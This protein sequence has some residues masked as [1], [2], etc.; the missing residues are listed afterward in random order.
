MSQS[1]LVVPPKI[2]KFITKLTLLKAEAGRLEL[3][4]TM[5]ALEL[6]ITVIGWE[7][8]GEEIPEYSKAKFREWLA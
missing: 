3:W 6:P 1:K 2:Q 5:H 8:A 7:L 4:R